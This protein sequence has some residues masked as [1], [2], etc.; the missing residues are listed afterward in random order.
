MEK[1]DKPKAR[2]GEL[3]I[4]LLALA[5]T[6][7]YFY[8]ILDAPWTAKVSTYFIG[9]IL[10][11]LVLLFLVLFFRS[12]WRGETSFGLGGLLKPTELLLR[13]VILLVLTVAYIVLL[14]W[15]GFTLTTLGFL[16]LAMPVLGGRLKV[17]IP[18]AFAY[19]FGGYILFIVIFKTRFPEGPLEQWLGMLF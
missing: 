15:G 6:L 10:I 1:T 16:L 2:G 11:G 18:L 14:Q 12:Y 3:I 13:R 17:A 8:S 19:A 4:P 9:S 5:F 7:Y